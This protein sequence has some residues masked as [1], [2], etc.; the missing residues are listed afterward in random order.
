MSV[1]R[2]HE[3]AAGSNVAWKLLT[4]A[5]TITIVC[6]LTCLGLRLVGASLGMP[7]PEYNI[8]RA[9]SF[10]LNE[11]GTGEL[12]GTFQMIM[13]GAQ[14]VLSGPKGSVQIT[15]PPDNHPTFK[16]SGSKDGKA[17]PSVKLESD[18][19]EMVMSF[20]DRGGKKRLML[21]LQSDGSPC[22]EAYDSQ[23][24]R[25]WSAENNRKGDAGDK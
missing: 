22:L 12:R 7:R 19:D 17:G 18:L 21:G 25:I 23:G 10:N 20:F 14:L 4:L 6:F 8:V 5:N 2:E 1:E 3:K 16:I 15:V 11:P 9:Q 13:G 24:V